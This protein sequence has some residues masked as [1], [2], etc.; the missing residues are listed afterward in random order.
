MAPI[1]PTGPLPRGG[2]GHGQ[3]WS[4][5]ASA[6]QGEAVRSELTYLLVR[7]DKEYTERRQDERWQD[8]YAHELIRHFRPS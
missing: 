8:Y 7:L 3:T 5:T 4:D 1:W 2:R 6:D